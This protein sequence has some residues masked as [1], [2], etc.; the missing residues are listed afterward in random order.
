MNKYLISGVMAGLA[1]LTTTILS[2]LPVQPALAL[3]TSTAIQTACVN[4][5]IFG[6]SVFQNTPPF[7]SAI[8]S[9]PGVSHGGAFAATTP[10][11]PHITASGAYSGLTP[12]HACANTLCAP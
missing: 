12:G 5:S 6:T 9:L 2:V 10:T 4:N 1:L 3:C 8:G 11:L 7:A